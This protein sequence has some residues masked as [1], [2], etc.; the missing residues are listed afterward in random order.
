M[1]DGCWR[2]GEGCFEPVDPNQVTVKSSQENLF[3]PFLVRHGRPKCQPFDSSNSYEIMKSFDRCLSSGCSVDMTVIDFYY[4]HLFNIGNQMSVTDHQKYW[5]EVMQ[6]NIATWKDLQNLPWQRNASQPTTG[7]SVPTNCGGRAN[8]PCKPLAPPPLFGNQGCPYIPP[9][10]PKS[11]RPLKGSFEGCCDIN[12]CYKPKKDIT[13][14]YSGPSTYYTGWSFYS[15]CSA[16]C[17]TGTRKRFRK[18]VSHDATL[19]T[20]SLEHTSPCSNAPCGE[21]ANWEPWGK[22]RGKKGR[23]FRR[24]IRKCLPKGAKCDGARVS[25][26]RCKC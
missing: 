4:T 5:R 24:R 8:R 23:R 9:T 15:A 6:G 11:M 25:R 3:N 7:P 18:C 12:I 22:C 13:S 26:A 14:S 20:E 21:W 2:P 1:I 19:C 16:E 10:I 17:G